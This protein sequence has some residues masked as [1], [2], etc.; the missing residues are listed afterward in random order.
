MSARDRKIAELG[1]ELVRLEAE[2]DAVR[3]KLVPLLAKAYAAGA[4]PTDL[5]TATGLTRTRITMMVKRA[6]VAMFEGKRNQYTLPSARK[7]GTAAK[8]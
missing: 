3:D 4:A 2:A 6:G 7:A 1:A 8:R 5:A